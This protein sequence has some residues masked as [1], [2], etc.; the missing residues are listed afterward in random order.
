[1]AVGPVRDQRATLSFVPNRPTY[2]QQRIR[3]GVFALACSTEPIKERLKAAFRHASRASNGPGLNGRLRGQFEAL[4]EL[5]TS[6]DPD[7]H[8]EDDIAATIDAMSEAEA[9]DVAAALVVLM[10]QLAEERWSMV[11]TRTDGPPPPS[12]PWSPASIAVHDRI[13][14]MVSACPACSA[15]E[16]DFGVGRGDLGHA[17]ETV[18]VCPS[19][20]T[21]LRLNEVT[22]RVEPVE[23]IG[24]PAPAPAP[25][26][27]SAS[28]PSTPSV[29]DRAVEAAER[30]VGTAG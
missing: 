24:P 11:A 5:V 28:S 13:V 6:G 30:P 25:A 8:G 7:L 17:T 16:V 29:G 1:V 20:G 4:M 12:G 23:S 9:T 2:A 3:E 26:P 10:W 21:M 22:Q 19:C 27:A 14:T 18:R 15:A